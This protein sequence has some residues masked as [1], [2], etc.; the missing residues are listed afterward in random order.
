[1]AL[2]TAIDATQQGAFVAT[3]TTLTADDT[4][5]YD[6]K[7]RQLLEL[8]NPTGGSLTVTIDGDGGTTLAVP[9]LGAPVSVTGGYSIAVPAGQSRAVVMSTVAAYCKGVVHLLGAAGLAAKLL[10]F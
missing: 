5:P 4:I 2:I 6:A 9:G 7:K 10:N 8:R 1:M 3:E